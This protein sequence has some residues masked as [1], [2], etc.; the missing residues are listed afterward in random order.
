[1]EMQIRGAILIARKAFVQKHFGKDAWGKVLQGLAEEESKIL[2]GILIHVGWY[3]F[4]MGEH[5]DRA[6]VDVLGKG[7]MSIFEE[8]GVQSAKENLGSIHQSFLTPGNPQNF[9]A[10]ANTI[11]KFYYNT[12][13]REYQKTGPN[14]GILTTFAA[15]T[16]SLVDCMTVIGWYKE[17]LRM[18]G[19]RN[20]QVVEETCRAKGD[21]C[22]Q[23]RIKWDI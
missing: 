3:P 16:Y 5:L 12:G 22:C 7:E 20:V 18:C 4:E 17:A 9:M 19:A 11:Y 2:K 10:Q 14:S 1:M 15:E 6:I 8:I 23:Y 21:S 13:Y